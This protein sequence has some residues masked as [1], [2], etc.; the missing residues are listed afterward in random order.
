MGPDDL[1]RRRAGNA[2][3]DALGWRSLR[4]AREAPYT[5]IQKAEEILERS[6]EKEPFRW[7]PSFRE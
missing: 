6:H 2:V 3:I 4:I 1:E 5:L 7:I